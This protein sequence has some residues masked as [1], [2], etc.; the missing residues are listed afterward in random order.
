MTQQIINPYD[1]KTNGKPVIWTKGM[2]K[3]FGE[4]TAVDNVSFEI[5]RGSIFGFIGPSGC[6]KTTTIRLLTGI[7]K[8]TG[9]EVSVFD[10]N[11]VNFTRGDREKIGYMPQS[12]VLYPDL[13]VWENLNFAASIYGVGIM[14]NKRMNQ[15]L[16]FVELSEHKHKVV[17]NISGGMKRRLSLATT[18][19]HRPELLFLDEPTGGIDPVLRRKFWDYF[20]ELQEAGSTLFVTT[21]YVSEA[22]YCDLVGIMAEGRLLFLDT[23]VGLRRRSMGG[24][25]VDMRVAERIDYSH[26]QKLRSLPFVKPKIER[27]GDNEARIIVEDASTA[28]P[29]LM[30]W[31]KDNQLTVESIQEYQPPYDDVFVSL[32]QR[33]TNHD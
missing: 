21:Q 15:L 28:L 25:A 31:A 12:F 5:P 24:D 8:P 18:L 26:V 22:A 4:Q 32:I 14:R 33:Y 19:V 23:P 13:S 6:G 9:G 1:S 16:D 2:T 11:P 10:R 7:Y 17:R 29:A 30:E 27:I 20:K 3:I